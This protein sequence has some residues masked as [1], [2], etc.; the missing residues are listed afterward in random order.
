LGDAEHTLLGDHGGAVCSGDRLAF[1]RRHLVDALGL[2]ASRAECS[3]NVRHAPNAILVG[4]Q[5]GVVPP[6]QA[7]GPVE[8]LDV[9]LDPSGATAAVVAQ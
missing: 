3:E 5:D 1:V 6:G 4:D 8:V 9:A 7:I 2:G